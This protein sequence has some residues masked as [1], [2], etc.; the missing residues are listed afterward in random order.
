VANAAR[1]KLYY[2]LLEMPAIDRA[3]ER[4]LQVDLARD[5]REET[6]VRAGFNDSG[7]SRNNRVI[8]RH[9]A[10]FGA[11]W[12][13]YDFKD[14]TGRQ[15][16]FENPRGPAAGRASF[17]PAG[18]EVIFNLP[19]GLHG[20]LLVDADGRRVEKAPAE[21]VSDPRRPDRQ[22]E[23]GV[24]CMSCHARG[25]LPKD[26]QVRAHVEK[27][28][29]AFRRA[30]VEAAGEV[31]AV[32]AVTQR[33]EGTVDLAEAA[34][35]AGVAAQVLA[36]HLNRSGLKRSLGP[37]QAKGGTVQRQV[38]EEVFARLVRELRPDGQGSGGA[39]T[40][41]V[42][43]SETFT[44][45][46]DAIL[47]VAVSPDGRRAASGSQENSVRLWDVHSGELVHTLTGH[48]AA[49]RCVAFAADGKRLLSG[50]EDR[51]VRLWDV[52]S[53]KEL[54]RL[55]GHIDRV[56]GVSFAPDGRRALSASDDRS[57]RLWDLDTGKELLALTG[58]TG[59]VTCIC[60]A[61]DG[62][63]ALSGSADGS[64]R[65]WDTTT[66]KEIVTFE[67]HRRGVTAVAFA[68]DGRRAVSGGEDRIVRLWDV[69]KGKELRTL[70]GHQSGIVAVNFS[71][72]GQ[73]VL[74]ANGQNDQ[75]GRFLR[76]WDADT[77]KEIASAGGE[78]GVWCVSFA[79][80]GSL[81]LSGGTDKRLH[82]WLL[83]RK[84]RRKEP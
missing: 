66:G 19:N 74:S 35:E 16:V 20:Y 56:R 21:I 23:V 67:A 36:R 68:P 2:D 40:P 6:V 73:R 43:G 33:F 82:L 37:L 27:N 13:S 41:K 60:F 61:P 80:D 49:V 47:C 59:P 22:V 78:T 52:S 76:V 39:E 46:T 71:S 10:A 31:E 38:F 18:G 8:E 42:E 12:R 64:V 84:G 14:N 51:T 75:P 54:R 77:G 32:P 15:N 25:L 7:V 57:V 30:D 3:L 28:P 50:S 58:H 24:S 81:A 34:A 62:R 26:D 72:D 83:H 79:A 65:L 44:G 45:H 4:L 48:T 53:S 29:T 63:R 5:R 55:T 70:Q 9:D 69:P 1:G 17:R 11:Y